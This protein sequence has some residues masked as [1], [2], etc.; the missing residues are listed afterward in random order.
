MK[1]PNFSMGS[2]IFL[3]SIVVLFLGRVK[4]THILLLFAVIVP[5]LLVYMMSAHYRYVRVM[6]YLHGSDTTTATTHNY[7]LKQ[8]KIGFG[9]GGIFGVG[10]GESKQRDL[11]LPESYGDFVFPI[12]GEEY[13]FIGTMSIMLL[14]L[15]I[16]LRGFRIA[17]HAED[18]FGRNLA[19][20]ITSTLCSMRL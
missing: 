19:L 3:L 17:K 15:F 10:P 2:I 11:F 4:V 1:Q 16:M 7:Q 18:A 9:N 5:I 13:G 8:G 6:D 14:F 20:T 12:I